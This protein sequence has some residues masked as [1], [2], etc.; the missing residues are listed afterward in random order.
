MLG[1]PGFSGVS[2]KPDKLVPVGST[3][4]PLPGL[5]KKPKSMGEI[6]NEMRSASQAL[7]SLDGPVGSGMFQSFFSGLKLK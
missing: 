1:Y 2:M 5:A 3:T 4:T 6:E 7:L